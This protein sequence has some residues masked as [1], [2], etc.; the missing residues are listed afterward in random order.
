[1]ERL[2]LQRLW[3][4]NR[5]MNTDKWVDSNADNYLIAKL[6]NRFGITG[7]PIGRAQF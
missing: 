2:V 4:E 1:M 7:L 5:Q 6:A 3:F